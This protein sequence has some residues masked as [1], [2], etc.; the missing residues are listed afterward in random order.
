MIPFI[1]FLGVEHLEQPSY[2]V[3]LRS[4]RQT[5]YRRTELVLA[6]HAYRLEPADRVVCGLLRLASPIYR[7]GVHFG[8]AHPWDPVRSDLTRRERVGFCASR[9]ESTRYSTKPHATACSPGASSTGSSEC[10]T[11]Q[12]ATSPARLATGAEPRGTRSIAISGGTPASVG[13]SAR[14][15]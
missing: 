6:E 11:E 4:N 3:R 1:S 7:N 8:S 2:E 10:T 9:V 12:A 14:R 13:V 5:I 15:I